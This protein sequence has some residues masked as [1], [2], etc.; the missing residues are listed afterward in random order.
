M[1]EYLGPASD[2]MTQIKDGKMF[3]EVNGSL[4]EVVQ[5]G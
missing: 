3:A 2:F 1:P 4:V 5:A